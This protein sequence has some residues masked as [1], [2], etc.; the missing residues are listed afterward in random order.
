[1]DVPQSCDFWKQRS[2]ELIARLLFFFFYD[3]KAD[4]YNVTKFK[5]KQSYPLIN[6]EEV[7]FIS[8]HYFVT[9]PYLAHGT[10]SMRKVLVR[11]YHSLDC[12]VDQLGGYVNVGLQ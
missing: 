8:S 12:M 1:M 2:Q 11:I 4:C 6:C 10:Q 7:S 3:K 5:R 9:D